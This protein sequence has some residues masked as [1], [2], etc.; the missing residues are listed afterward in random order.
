[1]QYLPGVGLHEAAASLAR[2][3]LEAAKLLIKAGCDVDAR[4]LRCTTLR[5]EGTWVSSVAYRPVIAA[6]ATY[7]TQTFE[8]CNINALQAMA[9]QGVYSGS[10]D[11]GDVEEVTMHFR[12]DGA[13]AD[14]AGCGSACEDGAAHVP[15]QPARA[16]R[17]ERN[18][19]VRAH[20]QQDEGGPPPRAAGDRRAHLRAGR[21]QGS[22]RSSEGPDKYGSRRACS[23]E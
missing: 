20:D 18:V 8:Y 3:C 2:P 6:G 23:R 10:F 17:G 4:E 9:A 12:G 13:G 19:C 5:A 16:R 15:P 11:E 21:E 14:G 22:V 1:M 7:T